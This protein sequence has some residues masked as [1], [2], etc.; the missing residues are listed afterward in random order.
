M[1]GSPPPIKGGKVEEE[2]GPEKNDWA[3]ALTVIICVALVVLG[4][5][6]LNGHGPWR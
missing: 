2:K 6:G 3:Y 4:C 5:L 1:S